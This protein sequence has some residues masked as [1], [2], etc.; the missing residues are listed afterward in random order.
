MSKGLT[1]KRNLLVGSVAFAF[2]GVSSAS[3][4]DAPLIPDCYAANYS[5]S[6][7]HDCVR[8]ASGTDG[9]ESVGQSSADRSQQQSANASDSQGTMDAD[10][11]PP[12]EGMWEHEHRRMADDAAREDKYA[13][14][15][16]SPRESEDRP[17]FDPDMDG[18]R[19]DVDGPQWGPP[20]DSDEPDAS[21]P[22]GF[23]PPPAGDEAGPWDDGGADF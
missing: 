8:R 11:P 3:A 23:G 4:E 14:P 18:P 1:M 12:P 7:F 19:S 2:L 9:A 20:P 13:G 21:G 6:D 17:P 16:D 5:Q 15:P 10:A 22:S